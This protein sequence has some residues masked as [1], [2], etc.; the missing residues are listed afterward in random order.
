MG[1]TAEGVTFDEYIMGRTSEEYQR[2]RRQAQLWEPATRR[3]L[4][5]TGIGSGSI[6]LDVGCGPAEVSRVMG[7]IV[8]PNGKITVLKAVTAL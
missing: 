3:I 8:G 6:C 5:E 7:E 4:Q 1:K 2:L